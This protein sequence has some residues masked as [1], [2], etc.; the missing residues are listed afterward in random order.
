MEI[1][2][3]IAEAVTVYYNQIGPTAQLISDY[4]TTLVETV[5]SLNSEKKLLIGIF[6]AYGTKSGIDYAMFN[7]W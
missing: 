4:A 5:G 3:D 1:V 2:S 6:G 7:K